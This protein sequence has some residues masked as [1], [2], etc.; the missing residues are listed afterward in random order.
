MSEPTYGNPI[1]YEHLPTYAEIQSRLQNQGGDSSEPAT[2]SE[3]NSGDNIDLTNPFDNSSNI[4]G[5]QQANSANQPDANANNSANDKQPSL[6]DIVNA[7]SFGEISDDLINKA[8]NGEPEDFK[9]S[10]TAMSRSIYKT[11][12]QDAN[13]LMEA[14][15]SKFKSEMK[16]SIESD[17][18]ADSLVATMKSNL[19]FAKDPAIEP[20]A[21]Q[22]L[23][24]YIRKGMSVD[25]AMG[26]TR[27]YFSNLSKSFA[28]STKK[29][30]Q[31]NQN[32]RV[33]TGEDALN[34]LFS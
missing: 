28:D 23:A 14:K 13:A 11:A 1:S 12:I 18:K 24:G 6:D 10:L 29:P 32:S 17:K 3:N 5:R 30:E 2:N 22:V 15:L 26:A 27:Q 8:I 7:K 21:R 19:E 16:A 4:K 34:K 33:L 9:A 20:V 25:E 31:N